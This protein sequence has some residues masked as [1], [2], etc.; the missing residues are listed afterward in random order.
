MDMSDTNLDYVIKQVT[1]KTLKGVS[2]SGPK[3]V[4]LF[5]CSTQLSMK[6]KLIIKT[7]IAHINYTP[8]KTKF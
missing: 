3:V 2:T 4:K 7:E 8:R 5:S 1:M 6:L